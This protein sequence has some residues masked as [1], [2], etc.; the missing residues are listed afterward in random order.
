MSDRTKKRKKSMKKNELVNEKKQQ[1]KN[2]KTKEQGEVP[3]GGRKE[4]MIMHVWMT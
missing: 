2:E 1:I 3:T 4:E